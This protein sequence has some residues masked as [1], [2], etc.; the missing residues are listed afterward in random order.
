M[1]LDAIFGSFNKWAFTDGRL[2]KDLSAYLH[3]FDYASQSEYGKYKGSPSYTWYSLVILPMSSATTSLKT[4]W[5]PSPTVGFDEMQIVSEN[6]EIVVLNNAFPKIAALAGYK[7]DCTIKKGWMT[8][9]DDNLCICSGKAKKP[10]CN[11][12]PGTA[13]HGEDHQEPNECGD[14]LCKMSI[15]VDSLHE[16]FCVAEGLL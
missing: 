6:P 16:L 2:P 12:P 8:Y 11:A 10:K 1:N 4:K 15:K 14:V 13:F 3:C 5:N 9:K 7:K